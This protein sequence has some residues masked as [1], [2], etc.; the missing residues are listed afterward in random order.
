[1][2]LALGEHGDEHVGPRHL[3]AAGGLH[4]DGRA[5]QHSLETGRGLG[6]LEA[7]GDQAG[8]L[9]VDV[10]GQLPL[11]ALHVDP[12]GAQHR[13]RVGIL[14]QGEQEMLEGRILVPP[15]VGK[16]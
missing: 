7:V 10:V 16:R 6:V 12:A 3:L 2:R 15:L 4:V 13:E 8:E 9:V 11:E 1:M 5:L 14:R